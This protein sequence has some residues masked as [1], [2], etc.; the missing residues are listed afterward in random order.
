MRNTAVGRILYH[1]ETD[2]L[3]DRS[4]R[5]T[6]EV[7]RCDREAGECL[8][9]GLSEQIQS[10]FVVTENGAYHMFYGGSMAGVQDENGDLQS[11]A[12]MTDRSTYID[13][14][15][16]F[17]I[18]LM[19]SEDGRTWTR[20]RDAHGHSRLFV[21]PGTDRDPC[22]IK[23]GDLWHMYYLGYEGRGECNNGFVC[24]TS[25]D[26]IHWS[27]WT[28]VHRD[29]RFGGSH[30]YRCECPHVVFRDGYFYLFRTEEYYE[31]RT[32]VFR[33]EDPM[34]FGIGDAASKYVGYFPAAAVE[35]YESEGQEY[36]SSNHDPILGTKMC[37]LQWIEDGS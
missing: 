34:D 17:Q 8:N 30:G 37:H 18:C 14:P 15:H 21:G 26:L 27:D 7:I 23:I 25:R 35:I 6:G 9:D 11:L 29:D 24:R 4:W 5:E 1:W 12:E 10:P 33:S 36:V 16:E 13:T 31:H 19:T 20:R 2:A 32:H 28:T 22:V 3:T